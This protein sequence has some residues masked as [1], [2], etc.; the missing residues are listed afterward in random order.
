MSTWY[1]K[2][3]N[4]YIQIVEYI[5]GR[6][7][8]EE[9]SVLWFRGIEQTD[10][11]YRLEPSIYR[12]ISSGKEKNH[13]NDQ[14]TY[15]TLWLK[16]EYRYQHFAARNYDKVQ[17]MPESMIEWQ[18]MMQHYFS[19]T[20]LMDWSESAIIAL[21]FALEAYVN[22]IEDREILYKRRHNMPVI[23]V[24]NPVKLNQ[25]VY[26]C[27]AENDALVKKAMTGISKID[28]IIREI[29]K[30]KEW[31]FELEN[32]GG[33]AGVNGLLSL[34]GLEFLRKSYKGSLE[35]AVEN[36]SFNP[37]F[38]LLLRYYADGLGVKVGDL[39]PLAIIHPHHSARIHEQK[40]AFTIFP[41]YY[42]DNADGRKSNPFA[43]E[44]M[45]LCKPCLEKI[46]IMDAGG[47]AEQLKGIGV[48]RSHIYPEMEV[49]AKDFENMK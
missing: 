2:S 1:A 16:E 47:M 35:Q 49:V 40:G 8:Q 30:R 48:R 25:A 15:G 6:Q 21:N 14:K 32:D 22:P 41:Y 12:Y 43:M 44:F 33:N 28:D 27:F 9:K 17:N 23:W 46:M 29:K 11:D 4:E 36:G 42:D 26:K 24:L 45:P 31:Y 18:E 5:L 10:I 7:K 39:T 37:F 19:K 3:L 20:R 13:M 34:S 38:Y